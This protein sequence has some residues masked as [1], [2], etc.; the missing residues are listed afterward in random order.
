MDQTAFARVSLRGPGATVA[1]APQ[2]S[3]A[4]AAQI[5]AAVSMV[6]SVQMDS[7]AMAIAN[8]S[9][10][11]PGQHARAVIRTILVHHAVVSTSFCSRPF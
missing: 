3:L 4:V 6:A 2:G 11:M 5:P 7:M 9:R 8:V 1:I 10:G